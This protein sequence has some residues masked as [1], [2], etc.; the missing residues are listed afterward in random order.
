MGKCVKGKSC[1]S[2]CIHRNKECRVELSPSFS[3]DLS[4]MSSRIQGELEKEYGGIKRLENDKEVIDW[5]QQNYN[6][7]AIGGLEGKKYGGPGQRGTLDSKVWLIGQEAYA[8]AGRDNLG[9]T[10]K[11]VDDRMGRDPVVLVNSIKVHRDLYR[12]AQELAPGHSVTSGVERFFSGGKFTLEDDTNVERW[13]KN[14]ANTY[15]GKMGRIMGDLGYSG[16]IAGANVSSFLQPSGQVGIK[17]VR[18]MLTR[19]GI[20][21]KVFANGVF[22]DNNSWYKYSAQKRI[23]LL[24]EKIDAHKPSL[25]Y[26]GQQA[27]PGD[28][29]GFNY[30]LYSMAEKK[31]LKPQHT[32]H[33]GKDYKWVVIDHP[34][35]GRTVVVNGWHPTMPGLK[36]TDKQFLTTLIKDLKSTGKPGEGIKYNP[37]S[38]NVVK[39]VVES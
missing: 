34:N 32:N 25:V 29:K 36:N 2:T 14:P 5:L 22:R 9:A 7:L 13:V 30:M 31:G 6:S 28:K 10:N 12:K 20:D 26:M 23:P 39:S 8:R 33:E 35:G 4:S 3:K 24:L 15:Y 1:K 17:S 19:N 27:K 21:P 38:E 37:V 11:E 16:N 18:D